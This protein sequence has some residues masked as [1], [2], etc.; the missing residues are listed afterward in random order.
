VLEG[1]QTVGLLK[2]GNYLGSCWTLIPG[3]NWAVVGGIQSELF[4]FDIGTGK[5]VRSLIGHTG[6]IRAL[7]PSPDGRYLLSAASDQTLRIWDFN[8]EEPLLSLFFAG[9]DWIAWTP[10]GYYAASPGGEQLMGWQVNNGPDKMATFYPAVQ[11]RKTLY[12]PDVIK[13]LLEAGSLEK[14]LALA[15]AERGTRSQRTEVADIVPPQVVI[16]SPARSGAKLTDARLQVR[17]EAESVGGHAVTRLRL[18]LDGRP[19]ADHAVVTPKT[20]KVPVTW[21]IDVPAGNH[22]LAVRA[23]SSVS[24]G[25]SDEI[26]V[27]FGAAVTTT[28]VQ[29]VG[30]LYLLAVGINAYKGQMRLDC[31]VPDAKEIERVF[32]AKSQGLYKNIETKLI[33]DQQATRKGILD[34][35]DWLKSKAKPGDVVVAFYA[36]HGDSKQAGFHLVPID[37]DLRDLARTGV[38]GEVLKQRLGSLPSTTMLLLD[39]CYAGAFDE[40]KKKKRS[41]P[42]AAGDLVRSFVYDEG[43]VVLCGANKNQEATEEKGHGYF[44]TALVEGLSGKAQRDRFGLVTF[45]KLSDYVEERVSELSGG[46]QA[47]TVSRPSTVQ[48]FP[49][50]RP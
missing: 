27:I 35:L 29:P 5:T 50:S 19:V 34:S 43:L 44:T 47:A 9:N 39:A 25:L 40:G 15:D 24:E 32:K 18:L 1:E 10:E 23:S 11:F 7:A 20:G 26:E 46:E 16:L 30:N 14:A 41:L 12:R 28:N 22:R 45:T 38:S 37:A 6:H 33:L 31:A 2:N 17:A 4:L 49:L 13:R 8:R 3:K 42:G 48:N 21:T 36:G